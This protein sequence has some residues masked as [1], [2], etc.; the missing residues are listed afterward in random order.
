[1]TAGY[2]GTIVVVDL[3]DRVVTKRLLPEEYARAFVGGRGLGARLLWEWTEPGLDPLEP[4]APLMF[5]TGPLTGLVPGGA[6]ICLVF[7]SPATTITLGH[8]LSGA[9]WGPELKFAGYDGLI[10]KGKAERPVYIV[11]FDDTIEIRDASHLWGKGTFDTERQLKSELRDPSFRVLSIGPAGEN[12]VR[13]ASVQQEY[14]RSAARGGSGAVMGS[15]KLKAIAVCGSKPLQVAD[16]E[17]FLSA[18][19]AV[20]ARLLDVRNSTRRGYSLKRWGSS[21]SSISH[22]DVSELDVRNYREAWWDDVDKVGGLEYE[23]QCR[24]KARSCFSCP[25]SCL[26]LGVIREGPYAGHI[27][28]PDFDSTG[29]IGPGCL[30]TDLRGMVYLSRLG[31]DLGMDDASLGNVV[32]FAMECYEKGLL[33]RSDLDGIDLRWGDLD[34]MIQMWGKIARREGIGDLLADG[35]RRAADK[36]GNGVHKFAMHAKGLEFAGYT[37]HAH[38]DR[39]LQY[40]VGD[41]GGCHHFGLTLAEQND[42]VWADS[43]TA[44]SWHRRFIDPQTY[45]SVLNPAVGWDLT[46]EDWNLWANRMLTLSRAYNV[47]EG[48]RP[49]R[50]DVLPDRVHSEPLQW[51]PKAGAVYPRESFEADR[52]AWYRERGYDAAGL[53]TDDLLQKLDLG[54]AIPLLQQVR[55]EAVAAG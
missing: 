33:S 13:F 43:M 15:K 21:I 11:V 27:V 24:V 1:M 3:T 46:I 7:K 38:P 5:L 54:F 23:R 12:L 41:R 2:T 25:I 30:L 17:T 48:M 14:F 31:D 8:A 34:A 6:Q 18:R 35:V 10:V 26:Q 29:T 55:S 52:A 37:P 45:L 53:P 9:S 22:S 44:C 36:I 19:K 16:P 47:R 20:E 28:N 50:D 51:G 4:D 40:A 39:A 42:R 49:L 32:G